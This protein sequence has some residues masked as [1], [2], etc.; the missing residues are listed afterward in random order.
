MNSVTLSRGGTVVANLVLGDAPVTIGRKYAILKRKTR[1]GDLNIP[2]VAASLDVDPTH[3]GTLVLTNVHA[4]IDLEFQL[5]DEGATI[6]LR[7]SESTSIP[8]GIVLW[9][10][11][12]LRYRLPSVSIWSQETDDGDAT[13]D[14]DYRLGGEA[15]P[16]PWDAQTQM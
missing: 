5:P 11:I 8:S 2:R 14:E 1:D 4:K 6:R 7:A 10:D 9:N 16:N 13:D 3:A 12:V 15:Q